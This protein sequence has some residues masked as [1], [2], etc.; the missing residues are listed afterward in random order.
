[1]SGRKLGFGTLETAAVGRGRL[2]FA[3]F[4]A[5]GAALL[6]GACVDHRHHRPTYYA[7]GYYYSAPPKHHHHHHHHRDHDRWDDRRGRR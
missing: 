5:L 6:L 3:A 4:A 7:P 1:M 2:R